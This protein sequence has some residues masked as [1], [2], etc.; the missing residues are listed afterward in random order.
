[1]PPRTAALRLSFAAWAATG[2]AA[3]KVAASRK[4]GRA[5][6]KGVA[7]L[8]LCR[9]GAGRP[10]TTHVV[11]ARPCEPPEFAAQGRQGIGR[12]PSHSVAPRAAAAIAAPARAPLPKRS[13]SR[14]AI[15]R[16]EA[17]SGSST[18]ACAQPCAGAG[19][20]AAAR[21]RAG[22]APT[23]SSAAPARLAATS[24]ASSTSARS[25][26]LGA[27][28]AEV[29]EQVQL[30][31]LRVVEHPLVPAVVDRFPGGA[32]VLRQGRVHGADGAGEQAGLRR[33]AAGTGRRGR[34][35]S[36]R[37]G[38]P[39]PSPCPPARPRPR[40]GRRCC[41]PPRSRRRR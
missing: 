35:R 28:E 40:H 33:Q 2:T 39:G 7:S 23:A 3:R 32:Q 4:A 14:C 30:A 22:C 5:W 12:A 27:V 38:R 31:A 41:A 18:P 24:S 34:A 15:W 36:R 1:M 16:G 11:S 26:R 37:S 17:P 20:A 19:P 25:C 13:G 9:R 10:E 8:R 21:G 29:L 6:E